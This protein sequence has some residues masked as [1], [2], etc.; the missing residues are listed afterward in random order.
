MMIFVLLKC[1]VGLIEIFYVF[2]DVIFVVIMCYDY[3]VFFDNGEFIVDWW[4]L[5]V[6][7]DLYWFIFGNGLIEY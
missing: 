6:E 4:Q 1:I 2:F 3:N 7:I 5:W